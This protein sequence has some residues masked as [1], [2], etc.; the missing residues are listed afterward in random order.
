MQCWFSVHWMLLFYIDA[1]FVSSYYSS[2]KLS[3]L[4]ASSPRR[5]DLHVHLKISV[6]NP[7]LKL[8][9]S[10]N[11]NIIVISRGNAILQLMAQIIV[12]SMQ[13]GCQS[14]LLLTI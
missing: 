10:V 5:C 11:F 1:A 4:S 8:S 14:Q 12:L 3:G 2:N 13:F 6:F 9:I 7:T